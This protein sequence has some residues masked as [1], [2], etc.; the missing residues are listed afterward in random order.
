MEVMNYAIQIPE[1]S[2]I[3]CR[4]NFKTYPTEPELFRRA[5]EKGIGVV[6]M[7]TLA[8]ARGED[9]SK[10]QSPHTTFRQAAL[11]WV[12]SNPDIS[13]LVISISSRDQVDEFVQASGHAMTEGE[14]A[15]FG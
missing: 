15:V 6:A 4:Y 2:L 7:K 8:G 9:L 13:N 1:I 11:K 14:Q 3:L 10:F 5:K 12:L